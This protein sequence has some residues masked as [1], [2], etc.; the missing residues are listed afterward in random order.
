MSRRAAAPNS[1]GGKE[2]PRSSVILLYGLPP[3]MP[4]WDPAIP[5]PRVPNLVACIPEAPL[6]LGFP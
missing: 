3:P 6:D 4:S 2:F 1:G 5:S